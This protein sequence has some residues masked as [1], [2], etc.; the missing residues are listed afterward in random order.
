MFRSNQDRKGTR[1]VCLEVRASDLT[2]IVCE[3][4]S[5]KSIPDA[6]KQV[7]W[8]QEAPSLHSPTAVSE[9]TVAIKDL[10]NQYRLSGSRLR[11]ALAGEFCVT[12]VVTGTSEEVAE[13]LDALEERSS[14][15]LSLGHGPKSL[16]A[17]VSQTDARHQH[18]LLSTVNQRTLDALL[19]VA[20]ATGL[21]LERIEPSLVAL[22]RL[23]GCNQGDA[24]GPVLIVNLGEKTAEV[25]ISYDGQLLLDYRP[26]GSLDDVDMAKLVLG[27]LARLNRYCHRYV[28]LNRGSLTR[29]FVAGNTAAVSAVLETFEQ[30]GSLSADL[31]GAIVDDGS[32]SLASCRTDAAVAKGTSPRV[33]LEGGSQG[34]NLLEPLR[35]QASGQAK[36]S[37]VATYGPVAAAVMITLGAWSF[38][39]YES[40]RTAV[41]QREMARVIA[42]ETKTRVIKLSGLEAEAEAAQFDAIGAQLQPPDFSE[43]TITIAGCM[44]EDVWLELV[45]IVDEGRIELRGGSYSENGV[46]EFVRWLNSAKKLGQV[47]LA[48]TSVVRQRG[49]L[50]TR[51]ELICERSDNND[52]KGHAD[53]N[54]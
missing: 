18:A 19:G 20:Q 53:G 17:S 14:L 27:H 40:A 10:V 44:P 34:P 35:G 11:I 3:G 51:F 42:M 16:A 46:Y 45:T 30:D 23:V 2:M 1:V 47:S 38:A 24:D 15:Y 48:S 32:R 7:R 49:E 5:S 21:E 31:V 41:I 25:G 36:T 28:H 39:W 9:L 13:E 26:P 50:A 8:R 22:S 54:G 43:L 37:L 6:V 4:E 12:R 52:E 29:V 33:E